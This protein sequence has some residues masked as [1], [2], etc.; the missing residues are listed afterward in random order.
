VQRREQLKKKLADPPL[1]LLKEVR[2]LVLRKCQPEHQS[3][4][5]TIFE[6]HSFGELERMVTQTI[7]EVAK[8]VARD[9]LGDQDWLGNI[10]DLK[11]RTYE[12]IRGVILEFLD[13]DVFNIS[14]QQS[15]A[16][17]E[18]LIDSWGMDIGA[19]AMDIRLNPRLTSRHT[20]TFQF[21]ELSPSRPPEQEAG[22]KKFLGDQALSGDATE[23]EIEFLNGLR[24]KSRRPSPIYY[25]RELQN[26]RD[27]LHFPNSSVSALHKRKDRDNAGKQ[28]QANSRRSAIDRWARNDVPRRKTP[29]PKSPPSRRSKGTGV[30]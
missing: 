1:S 30:N 29:K 14:P 13:T 28:Q 16:F 22:L 5:R 24:F 20:V 27:P 15:S 8:R 18:P 4:M 9:Q 3:Q 23:E 10:A 6:A 12:E 7:L 26:L 19:F 17:L 25:Y 11:G 2:E 21:V